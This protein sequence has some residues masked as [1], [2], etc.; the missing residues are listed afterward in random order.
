MDSTRDTVLNRVNGALN[1]APRQP[2]PE[3]PREPRV[4]GDADAQRVD[5][6]L[7]GNSVDERQEVA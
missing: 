3:L 2:M 7:S 1:A 4:P 6:Q 5:R